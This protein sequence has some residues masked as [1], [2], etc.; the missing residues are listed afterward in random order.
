LKILFIHNRYQFYGGEDRAVQL[1]ADLLLSKGH[2]VKIVYFDNK[3]IDENSIF[4]G[5]NSIY[6]KKSWRIIRGEIELFRPDIIHVHNFFFKVSPSVFLVAKKLNIP[7]V[8]TLHN[9]R[10]VCCNAFLLRN[11]K[12]CELCVNKK[13]PFYG[14]KYRCY[15]SSFLQ[16]ALVTAI[17]SIHK[18]TGTWRNKV[19]HYITLT[20]FG[21]KRF[22][23]SSLQI[24][25][26]KLSVLPNFEFDNGIGV[27]PRQDYFLFVGRISHEKGPSIALKTFI[28]LP[29]QKLILVGEG[30]ELDNLKKQYS[31]YSNI[32]FLGKLELSKVQVLMKSCK[33]LIFPS[34]WYEGLPFTILEA[35]ATGTPVIASNMGAMADLIVDGYNGFHF[36]PNCPED[37]KRCVIKFIDFQQSSEVMYKNA[38][39]SY[40]SKYNKEVHYEGLMKIYNKYLLLK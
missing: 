6:N 10:L 32:I 19:S 16:S 2:E 1:E 13:L 9:F 15:R 22:M 40:E 5:F 3:S 33:A 14:I 4:T 21:K 28:D 39:L 11:N 36:V 38:R 30:P 35:F 7:I 27:L 24:N 8:H 18:Y 25:S 31:N 34:I 37:L 26:E 17:T 12:V 29:D 23:N 20:E